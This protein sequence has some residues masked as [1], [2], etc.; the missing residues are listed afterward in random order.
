MVS[1][2]RVSV[3]ATQASAARHAPS[4]L[5]L[6]LLMARPALAM[7]IATTLTNANVI[8]HMKADHALCLSA[9]RTALCT[10]SAT[11]V[12]ATAATAT[13]DAIAVRANAQMLA[14]A[15]VSV[16]VASVT[17][18]AHGQARPAM[19]LAAPRTAVATASAAATSGASATPGSVA[20][21]V[22]KKH[23]LLTAVAPNVVCAPLASAC[24]TLH[25]PSTLL[26]SLARVA[27]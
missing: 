14:L 27:R 10:A 5:V 3:F 21:L 20:M 16:R 26:V 6:P 25:T 17:A 23:A 9:R 4:A 7:V 19:L 13:L 8:H 11:R 24:A 22:I 2:S 15:M 12:P 1:A 18:Q